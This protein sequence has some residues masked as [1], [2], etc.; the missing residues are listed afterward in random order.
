MV[1]PETPLAQVQ[2]QFNY[3]PCQY[4]HKSWIEQKQP[5]LLNIEG[6]RDN[7]MF[8]QWCINEWALSP[9]PE[10]AFNKPCH[11]LALLPAD[12]L[13]QLVLMVGGALHCVAMRGVVLKH[14]KQVL[15]NVFGLEGARFLIQNG[16]MLLSSWPQGWQH[17]LPESLD[18]RS[19]EAKMQALGYSW[20]RFVLVNS[21]EDIVLRWQFKLEQQLSESTEM[22][23][24]LAKDQRDLAYRLNK[25]N[26]KTGYSPMVSFVEIKTD[27]LQ[28]APGLKVLKAKDYASYLDSQ[29]LVEAANS[30]AESIIAN[31]Q[32]AYETEKQRGYQDGLAQAKIE[33]AQTMVETLARCNDYYQQVEEKMTGVVLEA[34][35]KIIDTFDDVDTTV[36]VV[37]EALQLV[38]NQK[39]VILHVHPEQVVDVREKVAGVLSDYPE[40][41]YVDVVA[42][43]RLKNGGC[44]LET[45][46]GIIDASIDGQLHA[47]KQAM[48]KQLSERK[49]T[50]HE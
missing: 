43:A 49:I 3:A 46:V 31:A 17:P 25:K 45:E 36:S 2:H 15:N 12:A 23:S 27:N 44:I 48:V 41:G 38:S 5:W 7:P 21:P 35:R 30:K 19:V 39:Q 42:D 47:L 8:N 13:N 32:Q 37:R 16:P 4:I 6:W 28:L 11:S 14:P 40:V 50:I 1:K 24:W 29:H 9:V 22:A 18:E 20:I 26:R 10:T 33:N 34:V